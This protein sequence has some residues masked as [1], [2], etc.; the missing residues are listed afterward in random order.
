MTNPILPGATLGMLGS[1]QLGRMFT[2]AARRLGYRVHVLSPDTETP[3]GQVAD[4]EVR[5]DYLDLHEVPQK[6]IGDREQ[7]AH[8]RVV[9]RSPLHQCS[10]GVLQHKNEL[11]SLV[12]HLLTTPEADE[13]GVAHNIDHARGNKKESVRAL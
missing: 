4:V 2:I 10:F 13:R 5:A 3:T 1:G 7:T 9:V 12:T 8:K 6:A 11:A